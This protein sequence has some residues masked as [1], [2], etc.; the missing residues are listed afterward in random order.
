MFAGQRYMVLAVWRLFRHESFVTEI[1]KAGTTALRSCEQFKITAHAE[2]IL[3]LHRRLKLQFD[4]V[5]VKE[6]LDDAVSL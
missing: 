5:R 6:A 3:L 4:S 1:N 2:F